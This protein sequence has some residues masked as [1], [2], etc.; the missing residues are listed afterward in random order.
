M[1]LDRADNHFVA[2]GEAHRGAREV[3]AAGVIPESGLDDLDRAAVVGGEGGLIELFEPER[4]HFHFRGG[5][6]AG[7][8]Q[9]AGRPI[10]GRAFHARNLIPPADIGYVKS[11]FL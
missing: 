9:G 10:G 6:R 7:F 5:G 3:G 4:L 1:D 11:K 8:T 2:A